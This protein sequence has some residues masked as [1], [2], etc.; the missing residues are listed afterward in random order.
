MAGVTDRPFRVLCRRLGA[1]LAVSEMTSSDPRMWKTEKSRTRM[2]HAGEPGPVSVQIAGGD[3]E[4]LAAAARFNVEHG[5]Q[6]IDVNMGCPAKKVCRVDAGSALLRDEALVARICAAVVAAVDVPVTLKIR[7]GWSPDRRNGLTIAR[8]AEDSGIQAL[9]V[10]GRTR[11]DHFEGSA[12]HDTVAAIKQSVRIPV[13]ANGDIGSPRAAA[14]ILRRTGVDGLMIG[15]AAQGRPWLFGQIA[16]FLRMGSELPEPARP[17][18][19]ALLL[20]HLDALHALYGDS[21]GVRVARK[22][23]QWYCR[24]HPGGEAFWPEIRAVEGVAAQ[25]LAVAAFFGVDATPD[26]RTT[27]PAESAEPVLMTG[28][29]VPESH[30]NTVGV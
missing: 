28:S 13:L 2:D 6:I 8:I 11:Q 10:H 24:Q 17:W 20:E 26:H 3:P 9:A 27:T 12:E 4:S 29:I 22:H 1:G 7:T 23:I 14:E 18:I 15:R 16:H 21:L 25:R 30:W 5:A 19:G